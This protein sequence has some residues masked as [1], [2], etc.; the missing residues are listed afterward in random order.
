LLGF[1]AASCGGEKPP[2]P[3]PPTTVALRLVAS[4]EVNPDGAGAAKPLRIRIMQLINTTALSQADFFSLD[5]DPAKVLGPELLAAEETS[6]SPG[7]SMLLNPEPK[8]GARFIGVTGAYF[9]IDRARW[10][11][12]APIRPNAA[13]TYDAAFGINGV[14]LTGSGA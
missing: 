6:L 8:Q 4:D 7:Q 14:T 12:W 11:A 13:N 10:R 5:A 1:A 3:L 9:A 2:P